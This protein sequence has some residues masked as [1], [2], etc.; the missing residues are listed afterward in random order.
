M[1]PNEGLSVES[2]QVRVR[3]VNWLKLATWTIVFV[4]G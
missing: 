4:E 1:K 3:F 2:V